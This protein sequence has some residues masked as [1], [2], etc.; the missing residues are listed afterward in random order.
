MS[1]PS[2]SRKNNGVI[3]KDPCSPEQEV[4]VVLS[5]EPTT[6]S[7]N[8]TERGHHP[9]LPREGYTTV[10]H[11]RACLQGVPG[12][13]VQGYASLGVPRELGMGGCVF[14]RSPGTQS[15]G[16]CLWGGPGEL[17]V[18]GCIFRGSLGAQST[19]LCHVRFSQ[20]QILPYKLNARNLLGR[21]LG[22]LRRGENKR[23]R[24][25]VGSKPTQGSWVDSCPP[26]TSK[27]DIS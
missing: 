18:G 19:G 24:R 15:G 9:P 5:P 14:G 4:H 8:L 1:S 13:S 23:R 26:G 27:C 11:G 2:S 25:G 17:R 20:W 21:L 3:P 10:Q 7:Q 6:F 22:N 16:L 12:S